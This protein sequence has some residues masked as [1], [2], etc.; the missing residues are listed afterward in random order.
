[1]MKY[2]LLE[3]VFS[4][5]KVVPYYLTTKLSQEFLDLLLIWLEEIGSGE[6]SILLQVF[7]SFIQKNQYEDLEDNLLKI[8]TVFYSIV[9]HTKTI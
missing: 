8:M 3:M 4:V 2:S 7:D 5:L 6:E 1:M 9:F